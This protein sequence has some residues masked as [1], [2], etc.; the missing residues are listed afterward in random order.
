MDGGALAQIG[1]G[2]FR[3]LNDRVSWCP[4]KEAMDTVTTVFP[5]CRHAPADV[6]GVADMGVDLLSRDTSRPSHTP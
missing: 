3:V 4:P 1:F 6:R 2:I 5:H